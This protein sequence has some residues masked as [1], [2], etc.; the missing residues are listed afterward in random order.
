[1]LN[2]FIVMVNQL[3]LA[4]LVFLVLIIQNSLTAQ[5]AKY[6]GTAQEDIANDIIS[7]N[8]NYYIVGTTRLTDTS[9]LDYFILEVDTNGAAND[10]IIFGGIH[11]DRGNDILINENG[12][13]VLGSTWDG[14]F[15]NNDMLLSKLSFNGEI[16]WQQFYGSFHNEQ[17]FGVVS[18]KDG[19]FGVV[20]FTKSLDD[21]GDVYFVK[22]DKN[23]EKL[24]E[25]NFGTRFVDYGFNLIENNVGEFILIGTQGGFYNPTRTDFTNHDADILIIKTNN[26]G[27]EVWYKT[28]GGSSHDWAKDIIAAPGGGYF[29][30]GSTQ[31]YGAGSFDV[32]LMKIDEDGNELWM[33]TFGGADYEYGEKV[34]LGVDG[35]LYITA[36]SASFSDNSKPDHFIIK[37]DQ[38]GDEI[39]SKTFGTDGS[40]YSSG[41]VATPDSGIVFTGHT[42]PGELGKTDVVF[43]KLSKDG[44]AQIIS[45]IFP[46]DSI[47]SIM[48]YPNPASQKFSVNATSAFN[49]KLKFSLFN[50]N[51]IEV[52]N[53][54][55]ITNSPTEIQTNENSGVYIY[56]FEKE[57]KILHSG[58]IILQL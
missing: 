27:E 43:Y 45:S 22:A 24:W 6:F 54:E 57:G 7:Y 32:F 3:K 4:V 33:K 52:M 19:G 42:T 14:G 17:G 35:N 40:D 12:I 10:P 55:I 20:G 46:T 38:N 39:W 29:I 41:L 47:N 51:G 25:N 15:S 26:R 49:T 44:D 31:T 16:E 37:T 2:Y 5:N 30:S 34:R 36:T 53:K 9:A 23:G 50:L 11:Q 48:V 18:C 8:Q 21:F 28:Y 56:R 13:F 1:M 58:K